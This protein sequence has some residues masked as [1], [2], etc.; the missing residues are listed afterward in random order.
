MDCPRAGINS[1]SS[2]RKT[3]RIVWGLRSFVCA[4][5]SPIGSHSCSTEVYLSCTWHTRFKLLSFAFAFELNSLYSSS[6]L[7]LF[8]YFCQISIS[9]LCWNIFGA[10][11][12]W[13]LFRSHRISLVSDYLEQK[14]P[15]IY[16]CFLCDFSSLLCFPDDSRVLFSFVLF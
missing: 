10:P 14:I 5:N 8:L 3:S 16:L 2:A 1:V 9:L 12:F 11:K 7:F 6:L 13:L 4:S 15:F